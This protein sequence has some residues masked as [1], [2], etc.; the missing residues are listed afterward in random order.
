[1]SAIKSRVFAQ[2][3]STWFRTFIY[4]LIV[5]NIIAVI[6][7]SVHEIYLAWQPFFDGFELFSVIVFSIEYVLRLWVCT[8]DPRYARP[9][10]GRFLFALTPLA[11]VDLVAVLP[12][13]LPMIIGADLRFVRILRLFRMLRIL[14]LGRY[15]RS[16]QTLVNVLRSKRGELA[17]TVFAIFVLLILASCLMFYAENEAQPEV[18]PNIPAAMW[19]G[20][21]TLTTVGYGDIYPITVLGKLI[22]SAMAILGIGLFALPAGILGAGFVEE[23]NRHTKIKDQN[24]PADKS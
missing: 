2:L 14:K 11:I 19:W 1:M 18:F 4:T 20:V 10:L 3:N 8:V 16:L 17:I 21:I 12:F 23:M 7:E 5:I 22:A 9:F 15:S 6:I 13:Y 24:P